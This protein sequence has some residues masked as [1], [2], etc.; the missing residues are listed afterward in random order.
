MSL[1]AGI[2]KKQ[3]RRNLAP[4]RYLRSKGG[5]L[6]D[7]SR[8]GQTPGVSVHRPVSGRSPTPLRGKIGN[9][10]P[11]SKPNGGIGTLMVGKIKRPKTPKYRNR[12]F[13]R[14]P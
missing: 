12:P 10:V 3:K 9:P 5:K 2:A 7:Y 13:K 8:V 6:P 11:V 1:V 4:N 14:M